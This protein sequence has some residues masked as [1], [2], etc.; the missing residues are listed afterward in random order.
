MATPLTTETSRPGPPGRGSFHGYGDTGRPSVGNEIF[1]DTI[2][3]GYNI[4]PRD[5][6]YKGQARWFQALTEPIPGTQQGFR[7]LIRK[8]S[9]N[10]CSALDELYSSRMK[11]SKRDHIQWFIN[12]K[13]ASNPERTYELAY[14][15]LEQYPKRKTKCPSKKTFSIQMLL[16]CKPRLRNATLPSQPVATNG[17]AASYIGPAPMGLDS[18][19]INP[20]V[21][22]PSAMACSRPQYLP[23]HVRQNH[24]HGDKNYPD[25]V[26]LNNRDSRDI[27]IESATRAEN[28]SDSDDSDER[29]PISPCSTMSSDTVMSSSRRVSSSSIVDASG[30]SPKSVSRDFDE[31]LLRMEVQTNIKKERRCIS[32]SSDRDDW[33]SFY[34]E[35]RASPNSTAHGQTGMSPTE[36]REQGQQSST[37]QF[38]TSTGTQTDQGLDLVGHEGL[39][40]GG[41]QC[42]KPEI[43]PVAPKTTEMSSQT[44]VPASE[45]NDDVPKTQLDEPLEAKAERSDRGTERESFYEKPVW[46]NDLRPGMLIPGHAKRL[47]PLDTDK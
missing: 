41:L 29:R 35:S 23:P 30:S 11:G 8:H 26:T 39:V 42:P 14:L 38:Y 32:K 19:R 31:N 20:G 16:E 9:P 37:Q 22:P 40:S 44:Q 43:E 10:S 12:T 45:N 3:E 7:G 46:M 34:L 33:P 2:Y 13:I 24:L 21:T 25:A 18:T 36:C 17:P 5:P 15:K 1:P 6:E 47:E 28:D 4:T 27:A